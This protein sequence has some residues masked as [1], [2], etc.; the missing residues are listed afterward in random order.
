MTTPRW[1]FHWCAIGWRQRMRTTATVGILECRH[2]E[3]GNDL[4]QDVHEDQ[5]YHNAEVEAYAAEL[6]GRND[7]PEELDGRVGAG[8][9]DFHGDGRRP[10]RSPGPGEDSHELD[11]DPAQQRQ[12][13]QPEQQVHDLPDDVHLSTFT[14]SPD[15]PEPLCA[16][17]TRIKLSDRRARRHRPVSYD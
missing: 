11:D 12:P 16:L 3:P 10:G 1:I 15:P 17:I 2:G 14:R 13:E 8:V 6:D 9:Q 7:L 4:H 5:Q